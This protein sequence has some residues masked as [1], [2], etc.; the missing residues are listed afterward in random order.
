MGEK[1]SIGKY[2]STKSTNTPGNGL[3]I[4][5]FQVKVLRLALIALYRFPTSAA[6][7]F[8]SPVRWPAGPYGCT[9]RSLPDG[10][11]QLLGLCPPPHWRK[12]RMK[13]RVSVHQN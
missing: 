12:K 8:I 6:H 3:W 4:G 7:V 9:C 5:L 2:C 11:M 1:T 10:N 13:W